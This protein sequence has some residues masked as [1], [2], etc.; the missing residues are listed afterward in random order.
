MDEATRF[1]SK[2]SS[3]IRKLEAIQAEKDALI[4]SPLLEEIFRE[5]KEC[6]ELDKEGDPMFYSYARMQLEKFALMLNTPG[7]EG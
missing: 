5:L 6:E 1:K 2:I 3:I 4:A 7:A